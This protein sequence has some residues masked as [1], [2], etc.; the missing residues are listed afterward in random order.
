M[1]IIEEENTLF[2]TPYITKHNDVIVIK[3]YRNLELYKHPEY[4]ETIQ[5]KSFDN[6]TTLEGYW[7][8]NN[9]H[10][11]LTDENKVMLYHQDWSFI[12][13]IQFDEVSKL[14]DV[15]I[16]NIGTNQGW[17]GKSIDVSIFTIWNHMDDDGLYNTLIYHNDKCIYTFKNKM[18]TFAN[19]NE[20]VLYVVTEMGHLSS[21]DISYM[22]SF[23]IQTE[24]VLINEPNRITTAHIKYGKIWTTYCDEKYNC[25][26]SVYDLFG[27]LLNKR[28]IP[29]IQSAD[30]TFNNES[31]ILTVTS[32]SNKQPV[33]TPLVLKYLFDA[34]NVLDTYHDSFTVY[35]P[36]SD[37]V[38][39][40]E[41]PNTYFH[42]PYSNGNMI[43]FLEDISDTCTIMHIQ[44][45]K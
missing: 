43:V 24:S 39:V 34:L 45:N 13:S 23:S 25:I 14:R 38:Y 37:N 29:H 21:C 6:D 7:Y 32:K 4:T 35:I 22:N 33:R 17:F 40:F 2:S 41:N 31:M 3:E 36:F 12:R 44:E 16:D 26:F 11:L 18:A 27:K 5:V 9:I 42:S 20:G 10:I 15:F 19:F 8:S 30:Y 1:P 28:F